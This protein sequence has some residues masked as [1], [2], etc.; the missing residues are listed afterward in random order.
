MQTLTE[1][2]RFIQAQIERSQWFTH[3]WLA[4]SLLLSGGIIGYIIAMEGIIK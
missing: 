4:I 1:K 3:F 2:F